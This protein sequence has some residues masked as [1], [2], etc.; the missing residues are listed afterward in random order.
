MWYQSK[1]SYGVQDATG[2]WKTISESFLHDG[3]SFTD[4]EAQIFKMVEGRLTDFEIKA[5]AL[6][7]F[8]CVYDTFVGGDFYK[9]TVLSEDKADDKKTVTAHLVAATD[10][11]DAEGRA[12]QYMKNWLTDNIITGVVKSPIVGVWHPKVENWQN[13]FWQRMDRLKE[14][15]HESSDVNQ[16][17][18]FDKDGK[19]KMP[20]TTGEGFTM[21]K[22]TKRDS[23]TLNRDT[24]K[25][26]VND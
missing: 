14:N 3:I 6:V 20:D 18:I 8:E 4:V 5:I 16:T 13:D 26:L 2:K 25:S 17:T 12:E 9:V 11:V 24:L 10:V 19:P 22:T 1:I 23:V 21:T 7:K 15:G